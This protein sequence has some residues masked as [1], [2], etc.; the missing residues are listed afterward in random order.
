MILNLLRYSTSDESTLGILCVNNKFVCYTIED[1]YREKKIKHHTRIPEGKYQIKYR[2][3]GGF[4]NRYND[5]FS[6]I[7]NSKGMLHL[8]DV[9]NFKYILIHIG[10][11]RTD[12]SGCILVGSTANDNTTKNGFIGDSTRA[13]KK[14]YKIVSAELDKNK[15][16]FISIKD[17]KQKDN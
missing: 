10:N 6:D 1:T 11:D 2:K 17:W 7:D 12:S 15:D 5:K 8:Q 3:E 13:Y 16:V 4:Y 9:P 14:I